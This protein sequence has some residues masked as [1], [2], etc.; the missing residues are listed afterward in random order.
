[1]PDLRAFHTG[2]QRHLHEVRDLRSHH[3]LLVMH[4]ESLFEEVA[5]AARFSFSR[6]G[7][8]GGQNVNR[9]A[10][11][12]T[13]RVS[14]EDLGGL[15]PAERER[16]RNRLAGRINADGDLVVQVEQERT[17]ARNRRIA[18]ERL[19]GLIDWARR[20]PK[21]RHPTRPSQAA[22]RRR[23]EQKRRLSRKK[24][25]RRQSRNPED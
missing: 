25:E 24:S 3:R 8:P 10:T 17:Q 7:G 6:S 19:A 11:K 13:A 9:R 5:S 21:K 20:K 12:V 1:M 23:L 4:R 22:D 14:L 15:S 18:L 2:A 16:A